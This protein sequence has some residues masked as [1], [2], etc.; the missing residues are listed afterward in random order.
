MQLRLEVSNFISILGSA[1]LVKLMNIDNVQYI[2]QLPIRNCTYFENIFPLTFDN[3][4]TL[5]SAV[6]NF[7]THNDVTN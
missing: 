7:P 2:K 4:T 3:A 1:Q 6:T 5:I